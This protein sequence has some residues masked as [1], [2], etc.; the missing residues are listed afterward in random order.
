MEDCRGQLRRDRAE[1]RRDPEFGEEAARGDVG[2]FEEAR[3]GSIEEVRRVRHNNGRGEERVRAG[4]CKRIEDSAIASGINSRTAAGNR[5]DISWGTCGA[6]GI[7]G[8]GERSGKI[9][10]TADGEADAGSGG[11][12]TRGI[13]RCVLRS[14][15]VHAG[16]IETN[17][18][19][20]KEIRNGAAAARGAIVANG[21]NS[22]GGGTWR[23]ELRSPGTSEQE[24]HSCAGKIEDR[25]DAAAW[26]RFSSGIEKICARAGAD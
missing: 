8:E 11:E 24:R 23:G 26:M 19:S 6:R 4:C 22:V 12:K 2:G 17:S 7:P 5:I 15:G 3:G 20:R 18:R 10:C 13:L 9:Y 21:S 14:R 16:A 25:G 1:G